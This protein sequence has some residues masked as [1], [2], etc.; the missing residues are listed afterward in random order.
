MRLVIPASVAY[1][2]G[3]AQANPSIGDHGAPQVA[4]RNVSDEQGDTEEAAR[5]QRTD[6][7]NRR[8]AIRHQDGVLR[9]RRRSGGQV[10]VVE[11]QSAQGYRPARPPVPANFW[12]ASISCPK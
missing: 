3:S 2:T 5:E 1:D 6:R 8:T 12:P 9:E 11:P 10:E 7:A 4:G